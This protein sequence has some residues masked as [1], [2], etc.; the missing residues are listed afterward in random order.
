MLLTRSD[1]AYEVHEVH[2]W[3][4]GG[5]MWGFGVAGNPPWGTVGSRGE[6]WE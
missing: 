2:V 1:D 3:E 6:P 5:E 4:S